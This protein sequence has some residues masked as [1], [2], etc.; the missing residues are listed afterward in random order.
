MA[1]KIVYTCDRCKQ[2][3]QPFTSKSGY[4]G[5]QLFK[6]IK[7]PDF[8]R[9][10]P[11]SRKSIFDYGKKKYLCPQCMED[12]ESWAFE[13]RD[14]DEH[15]SDEGRLDR[16]DEAEYPEG[17]ETPFFKPSDGEDVPFDDSADEESL[18]SF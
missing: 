3:Y 8:D 11:G 18:A 12:I 7:N 2:N 17:P 9:N 13:E 5:M 14:D 6:K 10:D 4:M 16:D 1:R 15:L